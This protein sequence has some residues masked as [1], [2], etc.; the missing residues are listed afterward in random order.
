MRPG[1]FTSTHPPGQICRTG[2][3]PN[4]DSALLSEPGVPGPSPK[5]ERALPSWAWERRQ[6]GSGL[7]Q[8][9]PKA[10]SAART[11]YASWVH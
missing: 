11:S 8:G 6:R 7:M 5:G 10:E 4:V 1:A 9:K 3:A 2:E